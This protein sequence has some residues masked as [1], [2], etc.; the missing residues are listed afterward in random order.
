MGRGQPR[1]RPIRFTLARLLGQSR[2]SST[3]LAVELSGASLPPACSPDLHYA[4][5]HTLIIAMSQS[6]SSSD[7]LR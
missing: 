2:P 6:G 4:L 5:D 7:I 1:A 3:S